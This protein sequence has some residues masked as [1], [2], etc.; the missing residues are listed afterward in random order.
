MAI[1]LLESGATVKASDRNGARA[2]HYANHA[3]HDEMRAVRQD[4]ESAE[5][6]KKKG[7]IHFKN[8][9]FKEAL[10]CWAGARSI[11]KKAGVKGHQFAVLLANEARCRLNM[12]DHEG[13]R[14]ACEEGLQFCAT[15]QIREKLQQRLAKCLPQSRPDQPATT[16]VKQ[17]ND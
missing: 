17:E 4:G 9:K 7:N 11:W 14:K 16:D 8:Q 1:R 5:E 2:I 13:A 10:A 12:G 3:G 15:D 6:L